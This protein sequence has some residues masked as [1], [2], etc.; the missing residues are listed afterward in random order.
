MSAER[1]TNRK[2]EVVIPNVVFA[3]RSLY[4]YLHSKLTCTMANVL[5]LNVSHGA[6]SLPDAKEWFIVASCPQQ[7]ACSMNLDVAL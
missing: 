3:Q 7:Q 4:K 6:R 1:E 2:Y 5:E